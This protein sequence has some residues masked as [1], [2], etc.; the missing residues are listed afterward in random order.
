MARRTAMNKEPKTESSRKGNDKSNDSLTRV[1]PGVYRNSQGKLVGSRGQSLGNR[2]N[3][4]GDAIR[5]AL[6]DMTNPGARTP[7]ARPGQQTPPAGMPQ[8]W[9]QEWQ[10]LQQSP[11]NMGEQIANQ[12]TGPN[13]NF[14]GI[15]RDA[16]GQSAQN[17]LGNQMGQTMG[18]MQMPNYGDGRTLTPQERAAR[19]IDP[20][21]PNTYTI[22]PDGRVMGTLMG[23]SPNMQG[24]SVGNA[25]GNAIGNQA[26]QGRAVGNSIGDLLRRGR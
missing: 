22:L 8:D 25:I 11:G 21:D 13:P 16:A 26:Q 15:V 12:V 6:G 1:S 23:W 4:P 5:N 14:E 9:F 10:R 7:A 19:G 24:R 17:N 2:D 3:K 18:N 20:R